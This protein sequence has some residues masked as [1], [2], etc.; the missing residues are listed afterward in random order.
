M[1]KSLFNLHQKPRSFIT[2]AARRN[3]V[4]RILV[5]LFALL[6]IPQ[7]L[8]ALEYVKYDASNGKFEKVSIDAKD[9][10][11]L[12]GNTNPQLVDGATYVASTDQIF[13][14][15][16]VRGTVNIILC[17]GT[18]FTANKG[19]EVTS[20]AT[21]NIYAQSQGTGKLIANGYTET[22]SGGIYAAI[23]GSYNPTNGLDHTSPA[24]S[25]VYIHGGNI[26]AASDNISANGIGEASYGKGGPRTTVY[27]GTVNARGSFDGRSGNAAFY[28]LTLGPGIT[29]FGSNVDANPAENAQIGSVSTYYIYMKTVDTIDLKLGD[30]QVRT[31]NAFNILNSDMSGDKAATASFDLSSNT[32]TLNKATFNDNITSGLASL[33]IELNGNNSLTGTKGYIESTVN[34]ATLTIRKGT[35]K[36]S[37]S[38]TNSVYASAVQGFASVTLNEVYLHASNCCEYVG[39]EV[40]AY[41]YPATE[42]APASY[43]QNL[44]FTTDVYYPLWVQST[45]VSESDK[46]DVFKSGNAEVSFSNTGTNTLTLNGVS[47]DSSNGIESGFDNLTIVLNGKNSINTNTAAHYY[48]IFSI[49]PTASLTIQPA[50]TQGCSLSLS[51]STESFQV[52][53]GFSTVIHSGLAFTSS[54]GT[55]LNDA[56]TFDAAL[57]LDLA[58]A[59]YNYAIAPTT[60]TGA[61]VVPTTITLSGGAGQTTLT[62]NEGYKIGGYKDANKANL[63]SAPVNFGNYYVTIEGIGNF[64][65]TVDV[66][67]EITKKSLTD[68]SIS[69]SLSSNSATY[70]G[71][72]IDATPLITVTESG[73][74]L[75][76]TNYSV[77]YKKNNGTELTDVE[78]VFD[79]GSYKVVV[80]GTGNYTDSKTF[81]F[82]V[83]RANVASVVVDITG[84]TYGN[85][86]AAENSPNLMEGSNPGNAP[87]N[88]IVYE[89]KKQT[90]PVTAYNATVPT[91]AG[92]YT[93]RATVPQTTNYNS[94]TG[95]VNF[96]ISQAA[97]AISFAAPIVEKIFG[98]ASFTITANNTGDGT[99]TYS[100]GDGNVATV[101]NNTG[102][103][104]IKASAPDGI[105]ITATVV[106]GTNYTY[107]TKTASYTL[108]VANAA[109]SGITATGYTGTYDGNAHGISVNASD[110]ATVKYGT[111]AGSY[112]LTA[113]PTYTNASST[114]Y[115]VYYEVSQPNYT[116]VVGSANVTISK[117]AGSISFANPSINKTFG[118]A[119]FTNAV[120]NTGDGIVTY[121]SGDGNVATVDNTGVVT[122]KASAPDGITITATVVDGTNYTYATKTASYTLKVANAAISG[123]TAT[124][125]T[126]TY[127]GNAHGISVNAS[128]GATVK[129]GTTA[130]SYTLTASP[131]YTNASSTPYVVY[132]E[133]SQPNYTTVVG[134]ANVT[135]SQAAG[136]IS[137]ANTS[138]DKTFG[139]AD[140]TN[141]L[142]K[143][144]DGTVTY[145]SDNTSVA[146]VDANGKVTINGSGLATITASV[147]DGTNYTYATQTA[148]YTLTVSDRTATIAFKTGRTYQTFY[149][150]NETFLVPDGVTAYI[151]TGVNGKS[152]TVTKVSYI[153]A[154]EPVLLE[155]TPGSTIAKDPSETIAGNLLRY[156]AKSVAADGNQYVLYSD[157]FV[158]ASGT[159]DGKVFLDL[160]GLPSPA[161]AFVIR[162]ENATSI[163]DVFGEEADGDAKWY[164]MQGRRINKPNKAGLYIKDG[165]KVVVK[166]R[167]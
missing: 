7:G 120:T 5:M 113:S 39:G 70:T 76:S 10:V 74:P 44:E 145:A 153:P 126:G 4:N 121:S 117:A 114:P 30:T 11:N 110:G 35:D 139:D 116:T 148:T 67:F 108:K 47:I 64:A 36:G 152:V 107:A 85:Y 144:G 24:E 162:T 106:D 20:G 78:G 165:K 31:T 62:Q 158:K 109:I 100:S 41:Q 127:D 58:N 40:L 14:R 105:T 71:N 137:F 146:T 135:I 93:V 91:A 111:T 95:T 104:T 156:A 48:P 56:N 66:P 63:S 166:T 87:A 128:D 32:L 142:N 141:A 65:G 57:A 3:A 1:E 131:T 17:D 72:D 83:N 42:A 163:E 82:T 122:I 92:D 49:V 147:V 73:K 61:A 119:D 46:E 25:N 124:G 99:V 84:W 68:P 33:T 23:G 19:I 138:I 52:V 129:Y 133:V 55:S 161:R 27:G 94:A 96:T 112:T 34:T 88:S 22:A 149:A 29:C 164:D 12:T 134:S 45:Q 154:A 50:N 9:Y 123:I 54:T 18:T 79:A 115:V 60:Y 69:V 102:A 118:D 132:Y 80:S 136:T 160:T 86:N 53:K 98:D 28:Y 103:V 8:L 77:G 101:D 38:L 15:L 140:F 2:E 81:D 43:V 90:D 59:N 155:S 130:G 75:P 37:L 21:L 167:Y 26:T 143:T 125:Y 6:L 89:Y 13:S 97:G 159:I 151:V 150:A 16:Y 157:E 51:S